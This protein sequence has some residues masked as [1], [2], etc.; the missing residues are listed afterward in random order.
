MRLVDSFPYF[1][2]AAH[3]TGLVFQRRVPLPPRVAGVQVVQGVWGVMAAVPP[4][5]R[6]ALKRN[7][8]WFS[9]HVFL[10]WAC[11]A[12]GRGNGMDRSEKV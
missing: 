11:G 4:L 7:G 1:P 10:R 9:Y 3:G 6:W 2:H 8:P 5:T 12:A